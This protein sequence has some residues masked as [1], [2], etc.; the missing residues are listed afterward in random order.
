M[1]SISH[2]TVNTRIRSAMKNTAPLST[3]TSR[4]SRP[5][6]SS[7]I[8]RPSSRIRSCS[9]SSSIRTSPTPPSSSVCDT[10]DR[11]PLRVDDPRHGDDL[12]A[13]HDERP[14]FAV[15]ARDLGVDEHVL[16]LP[17]ATGEPVAGPPPPYLKAWQPRLDTPAS[18]D[19]LAVE[20]ERA[21]LEP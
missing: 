15:G 13:P 8:S 4:S 18:P 16:H 3:P 14:T 11:H 1:K 19:D 9:R 7:E 12:V 21:R 2:G 10:Y 6:Y 5:S 20:L 17:L